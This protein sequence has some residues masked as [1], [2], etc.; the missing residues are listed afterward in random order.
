MLPTLMVND[1]LLVEKW[2]FG[3]ARRS[4]AFSGR[5]AG[6]LPSRGDIIVFHAPPS[7]QQTYV[8]RLIGLPGDRVAVKDGI[9]IL[10][11]RPIPRWP[12]DDFVAPVS[13]NSPC[14][15]DPGTRVKLERG[16]R[17]E[18]LCRY[19]R[20]AEMLPNGRTYAVLDIARDDAD[21]MA[22]LKVP[23]GLLFVLGDNRDR[24]ADSRFSAQEGGAVGLVPIANLIGRARTILLSTDGSWRWTAP[25]SW[26]GAIRADRI[27][28][29]L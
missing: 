7:G 10:N 12:I 26:R 28:K 1:T 16:D 9:V 19:P 14:H 15:P 25:S 27:L 11:G 5:S 13:P 4:L 18:G 3:A 6:A 17:G 24:S 22:E 29:G 20:Y 21:D 8:K 23:S 2:R